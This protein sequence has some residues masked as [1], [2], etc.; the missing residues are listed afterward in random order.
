MAATTVPN[1]SGGLPILGHAADFFRSPVDLLRRGYRENGHVYGFRILNRRFVVVIGP[2]LQ[3]HFFR[4]TDKTLD[5]RRSMPFFHAM[6]RSE[7]ARLRFQDPQP[8]LRGRDRARAAEAFLSRD[9]Q[10]ARPAPLDAVFPC[11]VPIGTGT[12][13]VSGS[14]TGASWS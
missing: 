8:A 2:E 14:S 1:I 10:D 12:S 7:R 9:G 11:H 13:T 4:E 5:L 3:K 6:F